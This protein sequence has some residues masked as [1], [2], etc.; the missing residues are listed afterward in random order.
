MTPTQ[1][2]LQYIKEQ[3]GLPWKTEV[4]NQWAKR[5]LDLFNFAD[6]V[7]VYPNR[8]GTTYIQV[9]TGAHVSERKQKILNNKY[10]LSVL[11][12]GNVI[13]IHGWRKVGAKGKRKMWDVRVE[14]VNKE[15][16]DTQGGSDGANQHSRNNNGSLTGSQQA[17]EEGL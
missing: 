12:A 8:A 10:A 6:I 1:R 7:A 9:T 11:Q 4:W 13:E 15:E 16:L 5:R 3:G 2:S 14:S 17:T